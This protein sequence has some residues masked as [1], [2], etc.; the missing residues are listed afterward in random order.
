M[1]W[2]RTSKFQIIVSHCLA[3][4]NKRTKGANNK[5]KLMFARCYGLWAAGAPGRRHLS[6]R[7]RAHRC[8]P[9]PTGASGP[10]LG[11][12]GYLAGSAQI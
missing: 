4:D 7:A 2:N 9:V 1:D 12:S 5:Q 8:P 11:R 3:S 10:D 6:R